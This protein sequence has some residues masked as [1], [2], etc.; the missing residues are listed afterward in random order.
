MSFRKM[1]GYQ[2]NKPIAFFIFKRPDTTEKVFEAIR[3]VKPPTLLV[4]ADGPRIERPGEAEK[5]AA[6][7]KIIDRV[8][9]NCEV[10]K[11]YSENNLGCMRR[12]S[13]GLDWVFEKVDEAIILEDDCL[14]DTTFFRFCEQLLDRYQ[15]DERIM[16]VC[17]VNFQFGRP[18]NEYSYYYSTYHDC[19][20]WATWR[21]AWQYYDIDMKLW[22][23]LRDSSFLKDKLLDSRAASYWGSNFQNAHDKKVDSWFYRWLFSCWVQNGLG[24]FP[25]TNLVSNIGVGA[26][27]TNTVNQD[28][29]W[30]YSNMPTEPISF[31]LKHPPFMLP[32][33]QADKFTQE[34]RFQ[35]NLVRRIKKK[36]NRKFKKLF[37]G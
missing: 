7:R 27:A 16:T 37:F 19:W 31:P 26:E 33:R 14:P 18:V 9:W 11:N 4:V 5:C 2:L 3:R 29:D 23:K 20:G 13:S 10:L 34:T 6:A 1:A 24:I 25:K 8:D 15:H 30:I 22:P 36:I 28:D 21:R 12:V 17:G 35:P 32:D